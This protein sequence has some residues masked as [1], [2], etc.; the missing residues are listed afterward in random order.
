MEDLSRLNNLT[1]ADAVPTPSLEA[2]HR[3]HAQ[4]K[5]ISTGAALITR[6]ANR[7]IHTPRIITPAGARMRA[8][9]MVTVMPVVV[10]RRQ[11]VR[12]KEVK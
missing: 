8:R 3:I 11:E 9:D 7:R 6:M 1:A 12:Q 2:I 5:M 10:V 4:R